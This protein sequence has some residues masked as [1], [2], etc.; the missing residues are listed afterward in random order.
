MSKIDKKEAIR[1]FKEA[2]VPRGIFAITCSATG[3]KWV[4]A[5]KN[6]GAQRNSIWFQ[7]NLG[8]FRTASL[9]TAWKQHGESAF[10]Y[11][12]VDTLPEDISDL[13]LEDTLKERRA[14][15]TAELQA[16]EIR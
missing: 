12:T 6:L 2:V 5:S 14:A 4:G 10:S 15:W 1:A 8:S 13:S 9:Q 11:E 3:E 16:Q 7:L